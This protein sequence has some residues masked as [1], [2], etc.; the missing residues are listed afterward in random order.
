MSDQESYAISGIVES[1]SF[2]RPLLM[3]I[4]LCFLLMVC[5]SYDVAHSHSRLLY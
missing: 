1:G 5:D 2:S 3:I 4:G